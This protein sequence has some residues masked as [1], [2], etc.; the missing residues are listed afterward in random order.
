MRR[1][2]QRLGVVAQ[3][4]LQRPEELC[5]GGIDELF[6]HLSEGRFG[7]GPQLGQ[8]GLDTGF[9][10]FSDLCC[11][12]SRRVQHGCDLAVTAK[13]QSDFPTTPTAYAK[14][15]PFTPKKLNRT[16]RGVQ[17]TGRRGPRGAGGCMDSFGGF[18]RV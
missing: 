6:G 11:G 13:G 4:V 14:G 12:R 17:F 7:G 9:A 15:G 16:P 8:E 5:V 18:V 2:G 1:G 3:V 10:V